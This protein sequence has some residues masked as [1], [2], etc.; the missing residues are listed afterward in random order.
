VVKDVPG[1]VMENFTRE[2]VKPS[3]WGSRPTH[4]TLLPR[5]D[6]L[7]FLTLSPR[8]TGL[9]VPSPARF[10]SL[11]P[12]VVDTPTPALAP[13]TARRVSQPNTVMFTL[14]WVG[15]YLLRATRALILSHG[16]PLGFASTTLPMAVGSPSC[17][18]FEA[19]SQA[20]ACAR[21]GALAGA[22]WPRA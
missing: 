11:T 16:S 2:G 21:S 14:V 15:V 10:D 9:P 6:S 20:R 1:T 4:P 3:R 22:S 13:N 12:H 7:T 19:A 5:F 18:A 17:G 8:L